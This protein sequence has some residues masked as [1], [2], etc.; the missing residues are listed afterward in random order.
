MPTCSLG[1]LDLCFVF[2]LLVAQK[3]RIQP[4]EPRAYWWAEATHNRSCG[5]FLPTLEHFIAESTWKRRQGV[6]HSCI[7]PLHLLAS[8]APWETRHHFSSWSL[9]SPYKCKEWKGAFCSW[10][11]YQ[12][13]A[14]A[15]SG[16]FPSYYSAGACRCFTWVTDSSD[17]RQP[18]RFRGLGKDACKIGLGFHHGLT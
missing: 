11:L 9:F 10:P 13:V 16:R 12:L 17:Q 7:S 14:D 2:V 18:W 3:P 5:V 4:K 15:G 8:S 1:T 6:L